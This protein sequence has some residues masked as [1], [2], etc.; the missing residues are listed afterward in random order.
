MVTQPGYL[1]VVTGPDRWCLAL[2][3]L[4]WGLAAGV[5]FANLPRLPGW[6]IVA[7]LL[8]LGLLIPRAQAAGPLRL[9]RDGTARAAGQSGTWLA[10]C[11]I[12]RRVTVIRLRGLGRPRQRL[13]CASGNAADDYR[14]LLLWLR[15]DPRPA[16]ERGTTA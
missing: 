16:S 11:W 3:R 6:A 8:L 1:D 15:F 12:T 4:A 10:G 2:Q 14:R 13:V 7:S 9:F 5:M